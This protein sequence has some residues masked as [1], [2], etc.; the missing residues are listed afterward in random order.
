[1]PESKRVVGKTNRFRSTV[2]SVAHTPVRGR[3]PSLPKIELKPIPRE[4]WRA[5][6]PKFVTLGLCVI[7]AVGLYEFFMDD[8]FFIE[9]VDTA[10]L[11]I[12]TP[13]EIAQ[14]SRVMSYNIFFVEPS[15]V[16]RAVSRMPEVKSARAMLGIPNSIL[17]EVQERVPEIV[18]F[19]GNDTYWVDADGIAMRARSPR[20]DLP[21]VR[22]FDPNPVQTGKR[23]TP[24][25]FETVRAVRTNWEQAPKNF[26]WTLTNGL[27]AIDARGW[28]II[29]GDAIDI[30]L[31]IVKLRA[32][33][34]R[35]LAQ[36]TRIKFID[37]GKGEPFYQ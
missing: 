11:N 31:K 34:A 27:S 21:S 19:K 32:L 30:E 8:H 6:R 18:W 14:A 17:I 22:D 12:L 26:D 3:L 28:K 10:G 24:A 37:L 25:A 9:R 4:T 1:M 13:Q 2:H 29:F 35:L 20:V 16:E 7:L 15:Q 23:V 36:G 5:W 33:Q